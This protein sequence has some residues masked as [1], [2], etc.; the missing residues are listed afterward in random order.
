MAQEVEVK[1]KVQ[2]SEATT[3]VQK[4]GDSFTK[5][6]T[7]VKK[8]Q[9]KST[10]YGKQLLN[11]S[12]ITS[13]LS[14]ATGGMSDAFVGAIRG[15]DLTNLSLKGLKG[16]IMSTGIGV[17]VILIGELIT[18]LADFFSSEKRAEKE[19]QKLT[20]AL[21]DQS[22]KFDDLSAAAE[23]DHEIKQ[24]LAK[25]NGATREQLKKTDEAYYKSQEK[26]IR[27]EL[28]LLELE[29]EAI[30]N[31]ANLTEE[32]QT[33][34]LAK[35]WSR[36]EKKMADSEKNNRD[37]IRANVDY[38]AETQSIAKAASDK[39]SSQAKSNADKA[40]ADSKQQYDALKNLE[41]KYADDIENLGDKTEE[42]KLET[43]KKRA[44]AELEAIKLSNEEK[45][46]ALLLI[47]QDFQLKDEALKKAHA[48]KVLALTN[49][50]EED[51][52]ALTAKTDEEKLKVS[53]DK[54]M[55]QLEVDLK[56]I[57]ASAT[58][59]ETAKKLLQETF[60][61]QNADAKKEK[62]E[63]DKEEKLALLEQE[64]ENEGLTFEEKRAA[65]LERE[66]LLLEDLTLTESQKNEIKN[67]SK[68]T[69]KKIDEDEVASVKAR[70]EAKKILL[71][72][73]FNALT[74]LTS[75]MFGEGKKAAAINKALTLTQIGIDTAMAFSKLMAGSEAAAV[76]TGPAYP[77]SKPIFYATGLIQ[78]LANVAKAK[79][80][81]SGSGGGGGSAPS[82]PSAP[83]AP[84]SINVVGA[85]STNAIAETIA[86][87]GQQPIKAFV[88]ANDVTTRQS[89]DRNI[90]ESATLG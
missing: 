46:N 66:R 57:N 38:Y 53:Q 27:Y 24:K 39:A 9:E 73:G 43:Q 11:N 87:Q 79:K 15:I 64:I 5:L 41:K 49:K 74:S 12:Q 65:N 60:D 62:A 16:A 76:A 37:S 6:D 13:K 45:K 1:I 50:L 70:E 48:E 4:L 54:A 85:S 81:L 86:Q 51:K 17:L 78:I 34:Q 29:R 69:A 61:L 71:E 14:Q 47:E 18:V 10:D 35:N 55:K 33:E 26:L 58:E 72:A 59:I 36:M 7:N 56:N 52:I 90:V 82:I 44:L 67:A 31:N 3:N 84:P 2:T 40:L 80:A 83:S 32:K 68:D 28:Y 8:T 77:M 63:K 20:Q 89:L 75:I 22:K 19:A 21:D 42:D 30:R 23:F 25:A 88:V